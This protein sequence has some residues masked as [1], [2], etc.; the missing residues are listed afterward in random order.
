MFLYLYLY[1]Y[2]Y[3]KQSHSRLAAGPLSYSSFIVL[4]LSEALTVSPLWVLPLLSAASYQI[5]FLRRTIVFVSTV[6]RPG[7]AICICPSDQ[8]IL[9]ALYL[10][11]GNIGR[12]KSIKLGYTS[13][14]SIRKY[15]FMKSRHKPLSD[16][17]FLCKTQTMF[18]ICQSSNNW[19]IACA[20]IFHEEQIYKFTSSWYF[21][22][23][24]EHGH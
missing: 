18:E 21:L 5:P 24:T 16:V 23:S 2:L 8:L 17:L 12:K 7:N 13:I 11:A 10:A 1:L 6:F 4:L 19:H 20:V 14:N 3:L 9:T 22:D 15:L